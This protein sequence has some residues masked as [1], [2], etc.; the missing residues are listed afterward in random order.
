MFKGNNLLHKLLLT[1]IQKTK[2]RNAFENNMSIN[3]KLSK[4]Q[5]SIIVQSGGLLETLLSKLSGPLTK[6]TV[7]LAKNVL[8]PQGI[9]A[10]ALAI[11]VQQ[12]FKK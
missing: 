5:I 6:V 4:S 10:A 3:K 2:L 7:P 12:V 11:D 9:T 8:A 1:T